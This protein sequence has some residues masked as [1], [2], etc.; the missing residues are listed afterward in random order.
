MA[1]GI[2]TVLVD[3][4][5][6]I[7]FLRGREYAKRFLIPLWKENLAY[8]GILSVYELSTPAFGKKLFFCYNVT[9]N[10][11]KLYEQI[12]DCLD[13]YPVVFAYVF[14]SVARGD[15]GAL[16]DVDVALFIDERVDKAGRFDLRL[17]LSNELSAALGRRGDIV[18]LNDASTSLAYEVIKHGR[19]VV[20]KDDSTRV[21]EERRILSQYLDRRYYDKRYADTVLA[22]TASEGLL[23]A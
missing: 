6:A 11:E 9:M 22:R 13:G 8:M 23:S 21:D 14:G 12:R 1:E 10:E 17:R 16:S 7:D 4:D 5:V 19:V 3:T 18:I 20:C 15:S 2:Q